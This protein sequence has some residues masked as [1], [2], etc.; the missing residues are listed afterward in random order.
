M[1]TLDAD[2]GRDNPTG[3]R[4][5]AYGRLD[6]VDGVVTS[7]ALGELDR[8]VWDGDECASACVR[9]VRLRDVREEHENP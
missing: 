7:L 1:V 4:A 9:A 6:A 8:V 3:T 2:F 5:L